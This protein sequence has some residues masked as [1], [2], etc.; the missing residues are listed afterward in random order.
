MVYATREATRRASRTIFSREK[1]A[2]NK[3]Y[4][5]N[6]MPLKNEKAGI[7]WKLFKNALGAELIYK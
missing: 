5:D 7:H 4:K 6:T 1:A 3:S 2:V